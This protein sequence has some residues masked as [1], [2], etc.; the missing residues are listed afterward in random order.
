MGR[1]SL[2]LI[3]A[4]ALAAV[5]A[6]SVWQYLSNV[7]DEVRSDVQE[8]V[9]YRATELIDTGTSV[10]EIEP[11]IE[12]ST[13]LKESVVFEGSQ[14]ACDGPTETSNAPLDVCGRNPRLESILDPINV[15]AGPISAGQLIT[16]DMFI[17]PN[18]LS[19]VKLS[20]S[21]PEGKVAI[22]FR[23]NE[24]NTVGGFV[25]PGDR[26]NLVASASID[27]TASTALFEDPELR[28][29]LLGEDVV[30][31]EDVSDVSVGDDA[32]EPED[33]A[34]TRLAQSLPGA[35]DF[36][37]TVLQDIKVLA[38]GPDTLPSP[39]GTG[40]EPAGAQ[41]VVLE[42][43]PEQAEEI[44]FASQYTS[45]SLTLI[46]SGENDNGQDKVYNPIT[47]DGV[48]VDDLFT[49]IDRIRLQ[50]EEAGVLLGNG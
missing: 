1:R 41:I 34:I 14:I 12:K 44:E 38:V 30:V 20:E 19:D 42:V 2:V 45:V 15:A 27:L 50:F 37:Q 35:I 36:T 43:T 29:L 40:L 11:L 16:S 18:L 6:F 49:L 31:V 23:P 7:E 8:V 3:I 17:A 10:V 22:S 25:R 39:L 26:V 33:D 48:I 47:S 21:I 24:E 46:P 5:S 13:A 4:L 32:E 9:V 28:K